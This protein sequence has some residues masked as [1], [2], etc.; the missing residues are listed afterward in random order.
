MKTI[1]RSALLLPLLLESLGLTTAAPAYSQSLDPSF[2]QAYARPGSQ[3]ARVGFRQAELDQMLA[4]VA[5]YPDALL[6]QIFMASTYPRDVA[7][8]ARYSRSHP[9]LVGDDAVRMADGWLWD[10]SVRSL[11][12]FPQLLQ[13]MDQR[14]D[15]AANLGEAFLIQPEQV[16]DTTQFLRQRA[17]AAGN[18]QS[19]ETINVVRQGQTL[20]LESPDPQV[21]YIPYYDPNQIYGR[22]WWPAHQPVGWTAWP[23]FYAGPGASARFFRGRSVGLSNH[24]FVG[25]FD[26]QRRQVRVLGFHNHN[27]AVVVN[28]TGR[29]DRPQTMIAPANAAARVEPGQRLAASSAPTAFGV[30]HARP[31]ATVSAARLPAA[32]PAS[33]IDSAR[34]P[35]RDTALHAEHHSALIVPRHH[36]QSALPAVAPQVLA[37][38]VAI[39]IPRTPAVRASTALPDPQRRAVAGDGLPRP[40]R[41]DGGR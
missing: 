34:I 26:W 27:A 10:P 24:F 4:P 14:S 28:G 13:L 31:P 35:S 37:P 22:W 23:G 7:E 9:E 11:L 16:I 2:A 40:G 1:A 39:A 12:A 29:R 21:I 6:A 25:A 20:M 5:L 41:H 36:S 33:Q 15:W 38:A 19:N 8:A 3:P 32:A 30:V 18:L 17:W